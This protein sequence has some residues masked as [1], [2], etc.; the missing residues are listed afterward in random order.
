[1]YLHLHDSR[2]NFPPKKHFFHRILSQQ[3]KARNAAT[4]K[5]KKKTRTPS[6]AQKNGAHQYDMFMFNFCCDTGVGSDHLIKL[7]I[8]F[9]IDAFALSLLIISV[10]GR[11]VPIRYYDYCGNRGRWDRYYDGARHRFAMQTTQ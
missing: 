7:L 8:S 3:M 2:K 6:D 9:A 1:M 11:D 4:N 10:P 5:Q